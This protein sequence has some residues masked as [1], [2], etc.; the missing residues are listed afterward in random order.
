MSHQSN[1]NKN[2]RHVVQELSN[3]KVEA[4]EKHI[5]R[6]DSN[7]LQHVQSALLAPLPNELDIRPQVVTF[8]RITQ[9]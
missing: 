5:R 8:Q 2:R 3:D 4:C 9:K 7:M 6:V 1:K